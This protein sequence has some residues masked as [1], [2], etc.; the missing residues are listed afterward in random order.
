MRTSEVGATKS[1]PFYTSPWKT[2][3]YVRIPHK[4]KCIVMIPIVL[5]WP[6]IVCMARGTADANLSLPAT[7]LDYR[8]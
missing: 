6:R 5:H 1:V 3:K 2:R 7:T 8:N 4:Y